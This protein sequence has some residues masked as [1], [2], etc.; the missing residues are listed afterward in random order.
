MDV[1]VLFSKE[2]T[3]QQSSG[4]CFS[5]SQNWIHAHGANTYDG[6]TTCE[7]KQIKDPIT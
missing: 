1:E 5:T 6:G 7:S 3:T 2:A 4:L